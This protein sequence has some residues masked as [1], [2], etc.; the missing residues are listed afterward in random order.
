[1]NLVKYTTINF[2]YFAAGAGPKEAEWAEAIES[3]AINGL[4]VM[5]K[6]WVD[7]DHF[8]STNIFRVPSNDEPDNELDLLA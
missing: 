6:V 2:R 3:G 8:V 4:I 1:M 7:E 5:G